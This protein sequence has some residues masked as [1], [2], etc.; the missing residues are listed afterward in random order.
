MYRLWWNIRK[1]FRK[2]ESETAQF[3]LVVISVV[4]LVGMLIVFPYG[5][6]TLSVLGIFVFG[7]WFLNDCLRQDYRSRRWP[8]NKVH[9]DKEK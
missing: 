5:L 9:H 2:P 3:L 8:F 1:V 6:F 7:G 4:L